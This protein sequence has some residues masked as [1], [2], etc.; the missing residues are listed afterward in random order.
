MSFTYTAF[1]G[2]VL[3]SDGVS[4]PDD[5]GNSDWLDYQ[6]WLGEGN[7]PTS[8]AVEDVRVSARARLKRAAST[9]RLLHVDERTD[10]LHWPLLCAEAAEAEVDGTIEAS[11]YSLLEAEIPALGATV[12]AVATAV[13]T[14]RAAVVQKWVG[15]QGVLDTKLAEVDAA[16][17]EAQ[18]KSAVSSAAWPEATGVEPAPGPTPA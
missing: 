2:G 8:L 6:A 5:A 1:D 3:R 14:K 13:L 16:N 11:E 9:Q 7:T 4:I 18:I 15:I 12:A 10:A 17:T